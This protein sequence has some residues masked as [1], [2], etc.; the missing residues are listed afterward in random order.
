MINKKR[1]WLLI[2]SVGVLF[3]LLSFFVSLNMGKKTITKSKA[4]LNDSVN[5]IAEIRGCIV[6]LKV[7]PEKRIPRTNWWHTTHRV[8]I[9]DHFTHSFLGS[10]ASYS[11]EQGESTTDLCALGITTPAG[12]YDYYVRGDSHLR[13]LY[14]NKPAFVNALT[15]LDLTPEGDLL[16]GET[17]VIY[18]NYINALDLS[19]QIRKLFVNDYINDLNQDSKVNSLDISNTIYNYYVHG[20]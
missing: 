15:D 6:K 17:S 1:I 19:T 12:T 7:H 5:I 9:Y 16:A 20:Q 2:S 14:P 11:N 18:D 3:L 4:Q 13:K 10:Y 8:D